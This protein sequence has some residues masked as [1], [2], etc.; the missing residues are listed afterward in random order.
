LKFRYDPEV[1]VVYIR[2]R[3]EK[4]AETNEI[5]PGLLLDTADDGSP[6]ALEILNAS[7]VIGRNDLTV[8]VEMARALGRKAV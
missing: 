5:S 3:E 7:K 8:E 2:F 6:V 4:I 1:D